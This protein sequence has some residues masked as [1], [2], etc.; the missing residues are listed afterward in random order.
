[1]NHFHA[2]LVDLK[3]CGVWEQAVSTE[4][5]RPIPPRQAAAFLPQLP[6]WITAAGAFGALVSFCS[7]FGGTHPGFSGTHLGRGTTYTRGA[8]PVPHG[9]CSFSCKQQACVWPACR[10]ACCPAVRCVSGADGPVPLQAAQRGS[11]ITHVGSSAW[12]ATYAR[13]GAHCS[14][15]K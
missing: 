9:L 1:M 4:H 5:V 13:G 3:A 14:P 8:A 12:S 11:I 10:P 2:A 6:C 15:L 7:S